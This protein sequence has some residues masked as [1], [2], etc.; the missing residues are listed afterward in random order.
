MVEKSKEDER[1]IL[2]LKLFKIL[3][4]AY[5]Q[6]LT[7]SKTIDFGDMI[8]QSAKLVSQKKELSDYKY[9]IIDEFQDI[10]DGRYDLILQF[11]N[12]NE[13]TKL[14]CVGD[15]WQAI[16]R[17]AGSDHK[18]MTNFQNLFGKT[19]TLKLD[20]T[21]RYNDQIAKVSEK[22]ITQNPS[23]IKK[24]LKTLTNKPDPQVLSIG[25]TM[26]TEAIRLAVKTIKDQH[27]IKDETLLIL[28][29]YNHN[30]LTEVI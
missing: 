29:R 15:D 1:T 8:S 13:N 21:F 6:E 18:I 28:S 4:N 17:F 7:K 26:T 25:I 5:Q 10:S 16:Y 14:F 3:L 27:L 11:L 22:F 24:D 23:Q 20:Q 30:K 12:Q 19:T 9:I 2:F